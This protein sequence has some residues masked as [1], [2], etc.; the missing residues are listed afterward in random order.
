MGKHTANFGKIS[1]LLDNHCINFEKSLAQGNK[2][3]KSRMKSQLEA[4]ISSLVDTK[5]K[6]H[7][8]LYLR[9]DKMMKPTL[10]PTGTSY[11]IAATGY[12]FITLVEGGAALAVI[13]ASNYKVFNNQLTVAIVANYKVLCLM[14]PI[15][16]FGYNELMVVS[17]ILV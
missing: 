6:V 1:L 17:K 5:L 7:N 14:W 13:I 16:L 3:Y 10:L 11:P 9:Y 8:L 4:A 2:H 12:V 15:F